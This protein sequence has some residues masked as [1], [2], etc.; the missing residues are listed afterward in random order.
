M[1]RKE[2]KPKGSLATKKKIKNILPIHNICFFNNIDVIINDFI[3][4]GSTTLM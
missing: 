2:V 3:D 4:I 1:I